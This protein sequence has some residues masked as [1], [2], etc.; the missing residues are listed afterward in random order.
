MNLDDEKTDDRIIPI[1]PLSNEPYVL[2]SKPSKKKKE[3]S[4]KRKEGL[5]K[6]RMTNKAKQVVK[7]KIMPIVEKKVR[8]TFVPMIMKSD[9]YGELIEVFEA[10]DR[11]LDMPASDPIYEMREDASGVERQSANDP[12][13]LLHIRTLQEPITK[14]DEN[15]LHFQTTR[16]LNQGIIFS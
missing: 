5:K 14:I 12:Q 13:D 10:V 8:E 2:P 11:M 15:V 3:L 6:A 16:E 4:D 9:P 1:K 7:H